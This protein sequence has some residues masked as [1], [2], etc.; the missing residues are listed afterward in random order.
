[1]TATLFLTPHPD[2][3]TLS[4]GAAIRHH[5]RV[6]GPTGTPLHDVHV[7]CL[8]D[9][10]GSAAQQATGLTT[11]QFVAARDD[12]LR[13]ACRALGVAPGNLWLPGVP[14]APGADL[15]PRAPGGTLTASHV[16]ALVTA[17]L[18]QWDLDG[19]APLGTV[20]LKSYTDLPAPH[21]STGG[22]RHPDHVASGT[23]ARDLLA[24]GLVG[25][26]RLY[27]EPW[28][29]PTWAAANP[30][31]SLSAERSSG[32]TW[33]SPG[34]AAVLGAFDEYA[35]LDDLPAPATAKFG[36]GYLSVGNVFR[37][38]RSDPVNWYHVP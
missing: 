5:L 21:P 27:L 23:A 1:V 30:G 11:P 35:A 20:N 17:L 37:Q 31:K 34:L 7:L 4:F 24:L 2:D 22:P 16:V 25:S 36:I 14:S 18:T 19:T 32:A 38:L 29:K 8:A 10:S 9:G 6:T 28:L 26:L 13:R 33:D 12:E 15:P 3:E